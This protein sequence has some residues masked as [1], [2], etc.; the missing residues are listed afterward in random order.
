MR[1]SEVRISEVSPEMR[2]KIERALNAVS[3]DTQRYIRCSACKHII[4]GVYSD[5]SGHVSVKCPKCGK[6]N[7]VDTMNMRRI[8]PIVNNNRISIR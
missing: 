2:E 1:R 8:R 6:I 4:I 7:L 3:K 5:A